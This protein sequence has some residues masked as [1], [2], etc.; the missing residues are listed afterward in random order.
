MSV[1]VPAKLKK[2]DEVRVIAPALSLSIISEENRR[3]ADE[4]FKNWGLN[5]TFGNN[6]E[7][8]DRFSSSPIESRINDLHEAFE[9]HNVKM[10]MSVIG[11]YNSNQLLSYIN[12][13][14][15]KKNPKIFCGYSDMSV[16]LNAI[17]AKTGLMTYCGPHYSSFSEKLN[18][19]YTH[20]YFQKCLMSD[21]KFVLHPSSKW[22]DDKWY[23]K[24]NSRH[25]I[26][27]DGWHVINEG[28]ARGRIIG[29]NLC[30]L[31]L[32]QGTEY[33]PIL[34]DTVLLIEDDEN[35]TPAIFDRNLQSLIHQ[36][37]FSGV[38]GLVIGR[39]QK[40]SKISWNLLDEII[41]SKRELTKIPV[42]ADVDFGH[43]QPIITFPI[44]GEVLVDLSSNKKHL[45]IL[46]H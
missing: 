37:G 17:F 18:F 5:L 41:L 31:N 44:G 10:I 21:K 46:K 19:T 26:K 16:L 40:K 6:T 43:T 12:W 32:L 22:S 2:G 28:N 25:F 11:G 4:R 30:T 1:I 8:I 39:F 13:S 23:Q 36:K 33:L 7:Q 34:K 27:N 9:D 14:L 20:E 24:Q 42:I 35:T 38:K 15:I 29:G 3:I 45:E